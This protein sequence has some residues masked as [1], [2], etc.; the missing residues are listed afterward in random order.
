MTH[1]YVIATGG[2]IL[3]TDPSAGMKPTAIA[4][5]ADRVLAVGSDEAVRAISRGDSTFLDLDGCAVTAMDPSATL[6]PGSPAD[7]VFR[8]PGSA[9]VVAM[10]RAGAFTVGDEHRGPFAP[11]GPTAAGRSVRSLFSPEPGLAY[12]DAATYGLPPTPTVEAM[13]GALRGWR[14]GTARWVED[15]DRPS[16]AARADFAALIGATAADIALIPS[17]SIGTGLV[18]NAL[19]PGDVVVVPQ[20]EHVSDLYPLLVAERRGVTVRQ[21]P[22]ERLVDSIDTA[23]TLVACSLVQM[24]TGRVADLAGICGAARTVGARVLIDSTHATPFVPVADHIGDIDFLVCHAYKHLL[25]A[26]G[27]AFLYVRADRLDDLTPTHANWRGA[28]DP[29]S[30]YFGGPLSLAADAS[31]F[32]VSLAWIPWVGTRESVRLMA[33]WAADGTLR[34]AMDLAA[35]FSRALRLEPTG[36]SLVCVPVTDV[37]AARAALEVAR[38]KAAIRGDGIRFSLHVWNGPDDVERA[39][40]AIT[41]YVR[42]A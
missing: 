36:S 37:Q 10:V 34:E 29:W 5:A 9:E 3:G 15:W 32:N 1:E 40:T 19:G 23:T 35:A 28:A 27:T 12:L 22:F 13:E 21:V 14:G 24:Q 20:D 33:G 30:T 31:R 8:R 17:V 2:R 11:R 42:D 38:V 6:E 39:I 25:G 41:P 26:R 18:A 4:W 7:L 16:D